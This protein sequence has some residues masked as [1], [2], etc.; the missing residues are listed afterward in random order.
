MRPVTK[1]TS[2]DRMRDCIFIEERESIISNFQGVNKTRFVKRLGLFKCSCGKEFI[3]AIV[4]I[5]NGN[6]KSCGCL[7]DNKIKQQGYKN[8]THGLRIHPL[9]SV[10]ISM[11]SRCE[12]VNDIN[13]HRYGK[14]GIKVCE[15]WKNIDNFIEDM[16]STYDR[17]LQIDRID[18]DGNYEL[19]N[20]RWVTRKQN[21]NNTRRN[22]FVEYKGITKTVGEWATELNI[23]YQVLIN[24]L[25]AWDIDKVFTKSY[26]PREKYKYE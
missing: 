26:Y 4:H 13:Y 14:R 11:V 10:W 24:R 6:V 15:R 8:K 5:R 21:A 3:A 16:F 23:P 19:S 20:C 9:Y 22:R 18:N 7:R 2:G 12:N 17:K 25:N 1:Y